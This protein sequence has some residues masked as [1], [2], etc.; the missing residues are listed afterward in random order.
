[1]AAAREGIGL[2]VAPPYAAKVAEADMKICWN[3]V[4]REPEVHLGP[5]STTVPLPCASGRSDDAACGAVASPDGGKH[6][7]ADV[8]GLPTTPVQVTVVLRDAGGATLLD[9]TLAVTPQDTYPN[10]PAC[11]KGSPQAMLLVQDGKLSVRN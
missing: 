2:D 1:M 7:F 5:S 10:G 4:C 8:N 11:G 9:R 6:G 3:G